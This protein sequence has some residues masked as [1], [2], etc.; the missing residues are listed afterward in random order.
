[1][2]SE[3]CIR[4]REA[5]EMLQELAEQLSISFHNKVKHRPQGHARARA[6]AREE[7]K[8][9]SRTPATGSCTQEPL[10][11]P[12]CLTP[13]PPMLVFALR[14]TTVHAKQKWAAFV[15]GPC[16]SPKEREH[17]EKLVWTATPGEG[18]RGTCMPAGV[19]LLN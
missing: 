11:F 19:R 18:A 15:T 5:P 13:Q 2:G 3:M 7:D 10:R 17:K 4:D 9:N 6:R 8:S 1:M 12:G 14:R 16:R